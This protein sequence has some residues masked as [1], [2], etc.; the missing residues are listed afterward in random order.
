MKFLKKSL[1]S[2]DLI[3]GKNRVKK[4]L[5]HFWNQN[6]SIRTK[7]QKNIFDFYEIYF[8]EKVGHKV[9]KLRTFFFGHG[10]NTKVVDIGLVDLNMQNEQNRRSQKLAVTKTSIIGYFGYK[11]AKIDKMDF[12]LQNRASSLFS[13]YNDVT[14][15][16]ISKKSL[17]W[18]YDNFCH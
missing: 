17:E 15:C 3:K 4:F 16:A 13:T 12:F 5:L 8:P 14:L 11:S 1:K 18:K 10:V 2:R 7:K 9:Q 6:D